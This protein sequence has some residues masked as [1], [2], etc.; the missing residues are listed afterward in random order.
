MPDGTRKLVQDLMGRL[1]LALDTRNELVR[2]S[3][4]HSRPM[5]A[6]KLAIG[7][8]RIEQ[9]RMLQIRADLARFVG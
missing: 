1:Q 6:R 7:K 3:R 2:E 9:E 5:S 4:D 8:A